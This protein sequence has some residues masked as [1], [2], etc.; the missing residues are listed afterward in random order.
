[1]RIHL[2][3]PSVVFTAI[4]FAPSLAMA[5]PEG[6][7][8]RAFLEPPTDDPEYVLMGEFVGPV[9]KGENQYEP[10]GL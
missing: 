6:S 10:L 2:I 1:M 3:W 9:T 8:P 4:L 5:Q 7:E